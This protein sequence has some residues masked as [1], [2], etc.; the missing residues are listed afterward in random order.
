MTAPSARFAEETISASASKLHLRSRVA[1]SIAWNVPSS[2]PKNTS[3]RETAGAVLIA[4]PASYFHRSAPDS[5]SR[6]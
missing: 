5:R 2:S 1:T 3:P 6:A 4:A